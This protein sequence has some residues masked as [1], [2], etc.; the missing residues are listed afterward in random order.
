VSN[1]T[2]VLLVA[3]IVV[4]FFWVFDEFDDDQFIHRHQTKI[5]PPPPLLP[6]SPLVSVLHTFIIL[7]SFVGGKRELASIGNKPVLLS[8]YVKRSPNIKRVE[9]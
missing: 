3:T 1:T 5:P 6:L 2:V 8:L 7:Y 9:T 4:W